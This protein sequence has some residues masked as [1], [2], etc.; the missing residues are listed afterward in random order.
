MSVVMT[1]LGATKPWWGHLRTGPY[2]SWWQYLILAAIGAIV[3]AACVIPDVRWYRRSGDAYISLLRAPGPVWRSLSAPL[4]LCLFFVI[5][6]GFDYP[7][8]SHFTD[9][10]RLGLSLGLGAW[11]PHWHVVY[12]RMWELYEQEAA[13]IPPPPVPPS[14]MT[15]RRAT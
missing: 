10:F 1:A 2:P 7:S 8:V 14:T 9:A 11:Y 12:K 15:G 4:W 13:A 3:G 5:S 6:G